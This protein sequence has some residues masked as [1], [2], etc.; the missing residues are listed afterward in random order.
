VV[1]KPTLAGGAILDYGL[2]NL[3]GEKSTVE[4]DPALFFVFFLQNG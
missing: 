3:M 2:S 1:Y 4:L